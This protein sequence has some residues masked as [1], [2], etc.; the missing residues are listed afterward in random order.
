M[1]DDLGERTEDPTPKRRQEAREKGQIARSQDLSAAIIMIGAAVILI[2]F[3]REM[4][5]S[6]ARFT[7]FSFDANT[8][9]S[10]L[11]G[12]ALPA[13]LR[14]IAGE[15]L[16]LTIPIMV[17][18]FLVAGLAQFTQVGVLFSIKPLRPNWKKFNI[19]TGLGKFF[20]K[21]SA[22]KGVID[23]LK[24]ALIASVTIAIAR[25]EMDQIAH[26]A[27]LPLL[28]GI[29]VIAWLLMRVTV[30]ILLILLLIGFVD[31]MFQ[32]W[33]TTQDLKMTR[34]EV[35]DER[36]ASEGDAEVKSRRLRIARQIA[37][38][39]I[40]ADVPKADVIVTNPTHYS[41]A[42]R[43]DPDTMAAPRVVAKGADYLAL[44]IRQ[45]ATMHG[46]PIVERPPLARA[47]YHQVEVGREVSLEHY[48]AVAEVLAY[49]YRLEG[50]MA[51]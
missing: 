16:R 18:M 38:Q 22:V 20:S 21:K 43:Y 10:D 19:I 12:G 46:V 23:I 48:E 26:L 50:K 33:Q 32:R 17:I 47:L 42:L 13:D 15:M 3:G 28:E 29:I 44:R 4:I 30:W 37:L 27:T 49:V 39:R 9:G 25:S 35:R 36:K 7:R 1:A 5:F 8:L 45:I 34:Q 24:L 40:N 51:S 31:W 2:A 14:I 6:M 11:T 41:V